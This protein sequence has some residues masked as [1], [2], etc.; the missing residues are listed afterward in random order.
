MPVAGG[1]VV[2]VSGPTTAPDRDVE[3]GFRLL[4]NGRD[5][6]FRGDI[7]QAGVVELWLAPLDGGRPPVRCSELAHPLADVEADFVIGPGERHVYYRADALEDERVELF[8]FPLRV[9]PFRPR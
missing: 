6:F 5:V 2:T 8:R 4:R 3:L 9:P 1:S 7:A